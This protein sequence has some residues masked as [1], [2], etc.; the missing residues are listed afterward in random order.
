VKNN[1]N[2]FR[3]M[4]IG[5]KLTVVILLTS[6]LV[7]ALACTAFVAYELFTAR[8]ALVR[9]LSV[10]ADILGENSTGALKFEDA[11]TAE[12]TLRALRTDLRI[13]GACLFA[14]DGKQF[15]TYA[16]QGAAPRIPAQPAAD[17][18]RFEPDRLVLFRPVTLDQKRVGTLF[19]C[20]NLQGIH[21]RTRSYAGIAALVLILSFLV[22]LAVSCWLQRLISRPILTLAQTAQ[23]V[24]ERKDYSVRAEQQGK[25][26]MGLLTD[27]FNQMLSE[28]EARQTALQ[29]A[30]QSLLAQAG[31]TTETVGILTSSARD[32]SAFSAQLTTAA[33]ESATAVAQTTATVEELRQTTLLASQKAQQVADTA[34]KT[35]Q[36]SQVGAQ[37]T[38]AAIAGM[39]RIRQQMAAIADSMVRLS[40]QTQAISQIIATV[41]DMAAQS[42]LLAVN[43]AIEAAKAGEQGKGF[44]VVAQEV[45]SLAEQSKQAT[46]QVR[47]ILHDI[48]KAT[49]AAVMATEQGSK[50]VESG[51][52]QSA[53]AGES[54]TALS[55]SVSEAAQAA[56]QIAASN[57]QQL[58]GVEQ[59]ASAMESIRQSSA[60]NV[61]SAKQL[62]SSA[63]NLNELGQKLK[64]LVERYKT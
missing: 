54:I 55:G 37:S 32:I 41:D 49:S 9:E 21:E 31:Q 35:A 36:V 12:G 24:T 58:I 17:G 11:A 51:V 29:Q 59:V 50:A 22:T 48:Q 46:N 52:K 23:A 62:E 56:S 45:R 53:Q 2:R 19:L 44:A 13:D 4:P 7:L 43:A 14:E 40:E 60:Q 10:L 38:E 39:Q 34:R 6:A 61:A 8:R 3:D 57:Q 1:M 18:H 30:N 33:T 42:N 63:R 26:E 64:L 28:I 5:Q 16:R 15:A 27:S 47:T 20:A 25:S